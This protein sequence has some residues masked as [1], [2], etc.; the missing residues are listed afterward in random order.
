MNMGGGMVRYLSLKEGILEDI[1]ISVFHYMELRILSGSSECV[2]GF[3]E[4]FFMHA[5]GMD[6]RYSSKMACLS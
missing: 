1:T 2:K 4:H 6:D 5:P 3:L